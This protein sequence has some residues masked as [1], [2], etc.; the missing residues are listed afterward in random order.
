VGEL[1]VIGRQARARIRLTLKFRAV[2]GSV[3]TI[4]MGQSSRGAG[5]LTRTRVLMAV[6]TDAHLRVDHTS[7]RDVGVGRVESNYEGV[8]VK[9]NYQ[10]NVVDRWWHFWRRKYY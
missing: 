5:E 10:L 8:G 6:G 3:G 2:Q 1:R 4:T 7:I 9:R